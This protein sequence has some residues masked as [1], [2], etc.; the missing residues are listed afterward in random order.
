MK[1]NYIGLA[2]WGGG[3]YL[4]IY[5]VMF[6]QGSFSFSQGNLRGRIRLGSGNPVK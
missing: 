4:F 5:N 3:K 1:V 2:V 6:I